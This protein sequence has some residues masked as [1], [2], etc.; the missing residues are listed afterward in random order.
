MRD[1]QKI[2]GLQSQYDNSKAE[3][4]LLKIEI[5]N[6]QKEYQS[7]LEIQKRLLSEISKLSNTKEL[8]VSEHAIIRYFERVKGYNLE[9]IEKEILSEDIIKISE[10]LGGT[11]KY[12]N[13][14]GF[15]VLIRDFIVT[16]ITN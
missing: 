6:K 11:G 15:M 16:T 5:S 4:D 1:I 3:S 8:K 9:E 13:K 14:K 2:K 10:T 7:K 12:P